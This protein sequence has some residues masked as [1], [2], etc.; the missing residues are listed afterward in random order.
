MKKDKVVCKICDREFKRIGNSHLPRVHGL[1]LE[2]YKK[3]F[4]EAE[5]ISVETR[6]KLSIASANDHRL[7]PRT[8]SDSTKEK[9]GIGNRGKIVSEESRKKMSR[10]KTGVK[11]SEEARRK[12]SE[13][14]KGEKHP[15][16]GKHR[17]E[18]T[19]RKV[20]IGNIGKKRSELT[21]KRQSETKKKQWR[22]P[23][24]IRMM[25][26]A[27]QRK[28]NKIE[29]DFDSLLQELFPNEYKYNGDFGC[30]I[31]VDGKIPDF[32]NINGQKK[33]IELFGCYFHDCPLCFPD[34]GINKNINGLV[35]A[36][37]RIE[38]LKQYGW[39]CFIIWEHELSESK[40][41][42]I[43]RLCNFHSK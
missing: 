31:T 35:E 26:K 29:M 13:A 17:S 43:E 37:K 15:N 4:P 30:G 24:Y 22:D 32:V 38:Q 40:E 2:E 18:E 11:M 23:D 12:N 16:F 20:S 1:T 36:E 10:A 14:K 5:T 6:K 34:G 8:L 33:A 3:M 39:D 19:K 25:T 28:P 27:L 7:H 41:L 42:L 9:V 21:R